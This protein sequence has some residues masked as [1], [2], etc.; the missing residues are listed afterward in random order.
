MSGK[1]KKA[2]KPAKK[3]TKTAGKSHGIPGYGVLRGLAIEAKLEGDKP[4]YQIHIKAAGADYRI[5]VNV[6]SDEAPSELLFFLDP[7]FKHPLLAQLPA[8]AEG[9]TVVP[10]QPNG[11]A[12]DFIRGNLFSPEEMKVV[13]LEHT[14]PG[15]DLHQIFE[16]HV[17]QAITRKADVY[18]FGSK[19]GPE[20][21]KPDEYFGFKPGNGIHDIHMNQGNSGPHAGDNGVWQDGGLFLHFPDE[22]RWLAFFLAFQSQTFHTD[23]TTGNALKTQE[24]VPVPKAVPAPVTKIPAG[25]PATPAL[26]GVVIV[27]A[28]ANPG[29]AAHQTVTLLNLTPKPVNLSGWSLVDGQGQSLKLAGQMLAAGDT[30][31]IDLSGQA[32]QLSNQGGT[33]TLLDPNG[34]K[35]H[36]VA[37]TQQAT[38]LKGWSIGF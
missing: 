18:A 28:L 15:D 14:G 4:H 24:A 1:Q 23:D 25:P 6:M 20:P 16:V 37:Y 30:A 33:L 29:T 31:R 10:K 32:L 8:L 27:A 11:I 7:D 5:A 26:P 2:K 9:F 19:W 34:L 38:G 22:N 3:S 35:I 36:G 17:Q 13:P 21:G 12:L